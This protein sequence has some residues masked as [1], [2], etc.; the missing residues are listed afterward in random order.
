[1]RKFDA[2][3]LEMTLV[4]NIQRED[5]NPIEALA[6]STLMAE[7]QLTQRSVAETYRQG[8]RNRGNAVRLLKLEPIMQD[9]IEEGKLSA[10]TA[11]VAA[12]ATLNYACVMRSAL[13][14][15]LTVRQIERLASS[16]RPRRKEKTEIQIT[17]YREA[18]MNATPS[19]T[20]FCCVSD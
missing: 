16:P 13:R 11:C 18:L 20:K 2:L 17:Q 15:R 6:P 12:V 3:A 7:F 5:L 14:A 9:W 1:V 4:E 8:P 19:G 10:G